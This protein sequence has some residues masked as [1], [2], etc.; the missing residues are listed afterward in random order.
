MK[1]RPIQIAWAHFLPSR[2]AEKD[3]GFRRVILR[4][5][6]NGMAGFGLLGTISVL[7][8]LALR[9]LS[10]SSF[11]W[12]YDSVPESQIILW[13]KIGIVLLSAACVALSRTAVGQRNGRSLV[14]A[15]A[16]V[17]S[18]ALLFDD[19]GTGD[20]SFSQAY[21][22]LVMLGAVGT[23]PYRPGQI[24][25]LCLVI[26]GLFLAFTAWNEALQGAGTMFLD[27]GS[28][29]FL[30]IVTPICTIISALIYSSRYELYK[31]R[32][33]A[34]RLKEEVKRQS[35]ELLRLER[36]KAGVLKESYEK[37]K[38][39]Q[40][41]LVHQGKMA[42]LGRLTAGIAHEIKNPLNFVVNYAS[43]SSELTDGLSEIIASNYEQRVEDVSG[44]LSAVIVDL[45]H[46]A[47]KIN[48]H[49][50]RAAAIV[51]AMLLHSRST[52]GERKLVDLNALVEEFADNA[53]HSMRAQNPGFDLI[54][55]H[56]YDDEV[57]MIELVPQ[58]IG[59]VVINLIENAFY[60][61]KQK[62][63]ES[64]GHYEPVVSLATRRLSDFVEIRI[65]DNGTGVD[66]GLKGKIFEPFYTTKPAGSGTG[67][68]LSLS[69]DIVTQGHGGTLSFDSETGASTTFIVSLPVRSVVHVESTGMLPN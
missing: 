15:L 60:A 53:Y 48:T 33:R 56:D 35:T 20:L 8:F 43:L 65:R 42:S 44:E 37:L 26:T 22:G 58:E 64:E 55:E 10:G 45:Q 68:G 7:L 67:L 1:T 40:A 51:D 69:H 47:Q 62:A 49:G 59:R 13:D 32:S 63:N 34:D 3:P 23:M 57:G 27:L 25:A 16:L 2:E 4:Q 50:L 6:R 41:R 5:T 17:A 52:S 14:A 31:A 46:N 30:I 18:L 29:R 12:S 39:M 38:A 9:F 21:L 28:A 61:V 19:L 11:G 36:E 54:L 66:E 24:L